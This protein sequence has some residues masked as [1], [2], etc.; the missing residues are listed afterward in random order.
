MCS[1][2]STTA[3][4]IAS[5]VIIA[6]TVNYVKRD[7]I[8]IDGEEPYSQRCMLCFSGFSSSLFS[9]SRCFPS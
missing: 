7:T 3:T 5:M 9:L 6:G 8:I 1:V 2:L 4:I